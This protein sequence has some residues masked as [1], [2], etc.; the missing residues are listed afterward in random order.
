MMKY[1]KSIIIMFFVYAVTLG[2]FEQASRESFESWGEERNSFF[3]QNDYVMILLDSVYAV[4]LIDYAALNDKYNV[5]IFQYRVH[6]DYVEPITYF[7]EEISMNNLFGASSSCKVPF[8]SG[9]N[10]CG[11]IYTEDYAILRADLMENFD[12]EDPSISDNIIIVKRYLVSDVIQE[13]QSLYNIPEKEIM[14][15]EFGDQYGNSESRVSL[16]IENILILLAVATCIIAVVKISSQ[17]KSFRMQSINGN[18]FI[19]IYFNNIFKYNL[20]F[21]IF[22]LFCILVV[23]AYI[24]TTYNT[25]LAKYY[26]HENWLI[27]TW[28]TIAMFVSSFITFAL[29][30]I[31]ST[32]NFLDESNTYKK[33][34]VFTIFLTVLVL[35]M[36][37]TKLPYE[38]FKDKLTAYNGYMNVMQKQLDINYTAYSTKAS[39]S[40]GI[41]V[42]YSEEQINEYKA[43]IR[44]NE[45]KIEP[46]AYLIYISPE[47]AKLHTNYDYQ[48]NEN[49]F[50]GDSCSEFESIKTT[51]NRSN[52]IDNSVLKN[53]QEFEEYKCIVVVNKLS[54]EIIEHF[55]TYIDSTMIYAHDLESDLF[56]R[57]GIPATLNPYIIKD[58][59]Y[60]LIEYAFWMITLL[61]S[62][63]LIFVTYINSYRKYEYYRYI[64]DAKYLLLFRYIGIKILVNLFLLS[65][66]V[67]N[68]SM[69]YVLPVLLLDTIC[70]LGFRLYF[71][72]RLIELKEE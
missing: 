66:I 5:A 40:F 72:N 71:K 25:W 62:N 8:S 24:A 59:E 16:K 32:F 3:Y 26:I 65:L 28:F 48:E 64:N 22:L 50:I 11:F 19:K 63:V 27:I 20:R 18:S 7:N 29:C 53:D 15:Y 56:I 31:S 12:G 60:T 1:I 30:Y 34:S 46:S 51:F 70:Y 47:I 57:R 36:Y 9:D 35:C 58:M 52:Q 37:V 42:E 49:Y 41:D 14:A 44:A 43:V 2:F 6:K 17:L 4:G 68:E 69:I 45:F 54:D 67:I 21:T 61:L 23:V 10:D 39:T 38:N 33:L 13:L 55:V